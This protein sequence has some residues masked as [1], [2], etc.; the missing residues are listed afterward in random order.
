MTRR[1]IGQVANSAIC[2]NELMLNVN[3]LSFW[4]CFTV[5]LIFSHFRWI[6][7][8]GGLGYSPYISSDRFRSSSFFAD[9]E[10]L[11]KNGNFVGLT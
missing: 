10:L 1:V 5:I 11:S 7:I 4:N 8:T 2:L 9:Y 6:G 3:S